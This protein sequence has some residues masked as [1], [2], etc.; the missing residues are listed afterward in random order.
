LSDYVT[1]QSALNR[2]QLINGDFMQTAT[3]CAKEGQ[4]ADSDTAIFL[5]PMIIAMSMFFR[6]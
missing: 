3:I 6:K 2:E 4:T 5:E 1:L